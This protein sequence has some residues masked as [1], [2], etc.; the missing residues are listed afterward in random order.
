MRLILMARN[1]VAIAAMLSASAFHSA[2]AASA[3]YEVRYE[4]GSVVHI[5]AQLPPGDGRLLIA[6]GGG[7]DQLPDQ[8]ATFVRELHVMS[9]GGP[10]VT[11]ASAGKQGW[12]IGSR[13]AVQA[14]YDVDLAYAIGKWPA[15]NEQSGRVFPHALYTV[16][17]P[18][19]ITTSGVTDAEVQF[20]IPEGWRE[21]TPWDAMSDHRFRVRSVRRLTE[22][23]IVL[24][25]FPFT[26]VR[27]GA[28]E[29]TI[30]VPGAS[31]MPPLL[32]KALREIGVTATSLF[33]RTPSGTY[34]MTF[35]REDSE[36]GESYENSAAITSP[37]PFDR[38]G[39]IVTG[40][41]L[42]H[43]LLHHWIGGQ[44]APAEHDSMAWFTEGF[45][46]YYA[47]VATARSGAVPPALLLRKF[48]NQV[49]GYLYFFES[50]L[51]SGV[52]LADA[53]RRKGSY[54]FG[55]YNGGWALALFLDV[56]LR[57]HT[58]GRGSLD[59]V[60]RLLYVRNGLTGKPLT[61]ADLRAALSEVVGYD[62]GPVLD[63][64]VD[65]RNAL[66]IAETLAKLGIELRGQTYAAD[67]FLIEQPSAPTKALALRRAMFAF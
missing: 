33:D 47:N 37:D 52:T 2:R 51:F 14:E 49:A 27:V 67:V 61:M 10:P 66:P 16:T 50:P 20:R 35:F 63:S 12:S 8:W 43:E 30:A 19:F 57:T 64:Y 29:I 58:G 28:F 62:L 34:L 60:M 31:T 38:A 9:P 41:T 25:I 21:A 1:V 24:G 3:S 23:S 65:K 11:V 22:N 46:E 45:T 39:M 18:L 59:D 15:G 26:E 42:V 7:I 36:D 54:R 44:I 5:S 32:V 55:V 6:Q 53:G 48:N 13:D 4:G 40:N 56:Q 17:R